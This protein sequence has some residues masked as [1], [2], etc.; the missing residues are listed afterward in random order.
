MGP[1]TGTARYYSRCRPG[2][3]LNVAEYL[4]QIAG[5]SP[6]NRLLD[7]G[8]GT[9]QVIEALA[10]W[11][12]D[13]IGIDPEMEMLEIAAE[14]LRKLVYERKLIRLFCSRIEDF[15]PP[16]DWLPHLTVFSRSFHWVDQDAT[17]LKLSGFAAPGGAVALLSDSSFD[18]GT[19]DWQ[20]AVTS[21][22]KQFL[23]EPQRAWAKQNPPFYR[24]WADVLRASPFHSVEQAS[25]PITR[26][27][28]TESILGY[29]Y[30]T[31]LASRTKFGDKICEFEDKL[32]QILLKISP[33]DCFVEKD[34]WDVIVGRKDG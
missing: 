26:V 9:G 23:G 2:L 24:P 22:T 7:V 14:N 34:Q 3:P 10:G 16:P 19:A 8:T 30:S 31:S 20:H 28:T 33:D 1:F 4:A 27:W 11:F 17:L 32:R 18:R 29:L 21:L 6:N 5:S 13:L 12:D 15:E 25:F